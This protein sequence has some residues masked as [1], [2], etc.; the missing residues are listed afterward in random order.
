MKNILTD[1]LIIG[2]GATACRASIE[3]IEDGIK[4]DLVD[5]GKVGESGS[6]PAC[7]YGLASPFNPDDSF[8]LFFEDWVKSGGYINDQNLVYEA[9]KKGREV[10]EGL[11]AFGIG[12]RKNQDGTRFLY[13]GAGHRMARG[14]TVDSPNIVNPLR[15]EAEKRGVNIHEG[16]MITKLFIKNGRV[17]GAFGISRDREF[18]VFNAKSVILAAGGANWLYPNI[19]PYII[20]PKYRTTGDAFALA[21]NA[22]APLIDME[23]TQFRESPPGAARF[24][25]RYLNRLGER[26]M[27][28][29]EPKAL[30]KAP[31]SKV[32]E[33][34]YREL[35]EGR[36][37]LIWEVEG[38]SETIADLPF[39]K[40]FVGK[41]HI[42][43]K[44]DFQRILGGAKINERGETPL[45]GLFSAGESSGGL[46]GGDRMQG[47][48]FLETQVFGF[49][50]GK[51][52]KVFAKQ[53]ER[54][55]IELNQ[56]EDEKSR[57]NSIQGTIDPEGVV[58]EIQ[59]IMWENVGIIR[60]EKSL[61]MA[62]SELEEIKRV[63]ILN[64]S[65]DNIF[66]ALE[67]N[68]LLLTAEMVTKAALTRRETRR[69]HIR[70]DYPATDDEWLKHVCIRKK[71]DEIVID[72]LP[73]VKIR[74][75]YQAEAI[76][77]KF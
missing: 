12:F 57:I 72:S 31:R 71:N 67:A 6:S 24:G 13:K 32:V 64:L 23:F 34:V 40:N 56:I 65:S 4:V 28:K 27:E 11:E 62:V 69:T 7:L 58:K 66:S 76:S 63:K 50:T 70:S 1:V 5:K 22:G 16:I 17:I 43:I 60:D 73:I 46:H 10:I 14:L 30:E 19:A 55:D 54:L 18:F 39:A 45:P 21:F 3:C 38:I 36:G 75:N 49:I 77:S 61:K 53:N 59:Q 37:P 15:K 26:F 44:I 20:E 48:G 52:A 2:G 68:N 25:G 42:E 35:K 47:N 74:H 33:A 41:K 51:N 8:D 29:Y 9:I